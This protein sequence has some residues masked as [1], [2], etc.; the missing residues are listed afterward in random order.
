MA[1]ISL[2]SN[3]L[4]YAEGTADLPKRDI[5]VPLITR[6]GPENIVVPMQAAGE[7]L[8]W[9]I[10]KGRLD[11]SAAVR[12]IEWWITECEALPVSVEAFRHATSL[13]ERHAFQLWDA[14]ILAASAEAEATFLLSEDMQ[15]GFRWRGVTIIN[16]F[17]LT[18]EEQRSLV[19]PRALH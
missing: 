10:R 12:R 2:D 19:P 8:R 11:R 1:R 5:V 4:I 3:I 13:V 14:V 17:L 7:T 16:P 15:H 18:P 9:L 6:I